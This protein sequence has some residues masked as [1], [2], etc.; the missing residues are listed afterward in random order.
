MS[1]EI[2][3]GV[4][5]KYT[6]E[7]NET[8][9]VIPDT[10]TGIGENAFRWCSDLKKVTIPDSVTYIESFAFFE[11]PH[12]EEVIIPDSV[13]SIGNLAFHYCRNLKEITIPNSVRYI[14]EETFNYCSSLKKVTIPDSVISTDDR[15]FEYCLELKEIIIPHSVTNIGNGV[16]KGCSEL[17]KVTIPDSV[18]SIGHS[19]FKG[20]DN[21]KEVII[22]NSVTNIGYSAF[23]WCNKLEKVT[24]GNSVTSLW[25]IFDKFSNLK[26]VTINGVTFKPYIKKLI[27]DYEKA[28]I[29]L[30]TKD[31]SAKVYTPLKKAI[32]IGYYL[33]TADKDA[34]EYIRKRTV[35]M[36]RWLIDEEDIPT[37]YALLKTGE[38]ITSKN[39]DKLSEYAE[40]NDKTEIKSIFINYKNENYG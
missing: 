34:E 12:L 32:I 22:G 8:K 14:S 1:F 31:F 28:I 20:C 33:N 13:K 10:V 26:Q 15:A 4:L 29:M 3:N 2:E 24:I 38:F 25:H 6:A 23:G 27:K 21:L 39:I 5:K 17:N 35:E 40:Q 9:V 11:C 30:E 36:F 16:F 19:A 7:G 18:T 37:I